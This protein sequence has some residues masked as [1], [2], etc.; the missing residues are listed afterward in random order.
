MSLSRAIRLA[1]KV[2]LNN[3]EYYRDVDN[4]IVSSEGTKILLKDFLLQNAGQKVFIAVYKNDTQ[5]VI[6]LTDPEYW[7]KIDLENLRQQALDERHQKELQILEHKK[8]LSET[9]YKVL[10]DYDKV[11]TVPEIKAKRQEARD[12]IRMLEQELATTPF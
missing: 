4:T 8:Y 1:K 6:D 2:I 3:V 5:E 7:H 12:M 11:E 10:P 9:D